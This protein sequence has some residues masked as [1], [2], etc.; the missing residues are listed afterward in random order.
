MSLPCQD[1]RAQGAR[2]ALGEAELERLAALSPV[3]IPHAGQEP[4]K[5]AG[6]AAGRAAQTLDPDP[7]VGSG[8]PAKVPGAA[9]ALAGAAGAAQAA[10]PAFYGAHRVFMAPLP[11]EPVPGRRPRPAGVLSM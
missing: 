3:S 9:A 6:H 5:P 4:S 11:A 8:T 1:L 10:V 7:A 2:E